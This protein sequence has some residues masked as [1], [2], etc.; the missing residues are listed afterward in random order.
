MIYNTKT[1]K[2]R[3]YDLSMIFARYAFVEFED[4][5]DAR[6]AYKQADGRKIDG[7]R[8]MVDVERGT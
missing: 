2:P 7:K 4:E 6:T 1:G 5:R 8:V 3:G